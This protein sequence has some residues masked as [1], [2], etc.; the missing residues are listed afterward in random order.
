MLIRLTYASRSTGALGPSDVKDIVRTSQRNNARLG[1]TGALLL[2][3]GIFLQCLEGDLPS[4][5]AL[6]HRIVMDSRHREPAILNFT[7]ID[8]RLHGAWSMGLV[9]GT[10]ENRELLMR[11]SP[12]A[13]FDPY[14]IRPRALDALFAELVD[15]ARVLAA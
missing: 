6:Y 1:I 14:A 15:R 12:S 9:P 7:E 5:N 3:D 8:T 2:A 11:Y 10:A 13:T 4:V